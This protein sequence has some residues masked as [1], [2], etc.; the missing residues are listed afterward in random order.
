MVLR[1]YSRVVVGGDTQ[2]SVGKH[3]VN[4]SDVEWDE[5]DFEP[6]VVVA[7]KL[8]DKWAGEDEE[9]DVKDNW[10]DE[11]EEGGGGGDENKT[12]NNNMPAPLKKKKKKFSEIIA[13]KEAKEA[14]EAEKRR[15]EMEEREKSMTAEGKLAEKLRLQ[16]IQEE[17]DLQLASEFIGGEGEEVGEHTPPLSHEETPS[18][19]QSSVA[20]DPSPLDSYSLTT[21]ESLKD[22]RTA[23]I[24]KIRSVDRLEKRAIYLPFVEELIRDLCL[25]LEVEDVKKVT[26]SLNTLYNE[27]VKAN[28]PVKGKKKSANKAKLNPGQGA[29]TDDVANDF[30]DYDDFI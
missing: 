18:R 21:S 9:D 6:R 2:S 25:N 27:K 19:V 8:T 22:F 11:E 17:S 10:D 16:K 13:A 4:M 26:S 15:K 3:R 23:L 14:E 5:E 24:A 30:Y 7:P 28:K 20:E 29:I 12:G 1:W